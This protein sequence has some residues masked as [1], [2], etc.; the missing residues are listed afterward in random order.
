[1][2]I[3][4]SSPFH[5]GKTMATSVTVKLDPITRIEGHLSVE[6]VVDDGV[7]K[8]ANVSGTLFCGFETIMQGHS[9]LDAI[10]FAQRF[11]RVGPT[12]HA[13]ASAQALDQAFGIIPTETGRVI[14]NLVGGAKWIQSHLLHFC[15]LSA[16]DYFPD[17]CSPPFIPHF[18]GDYRLPR[19]LNEE[20]L[21]AY[22]LALSMRLKAHELSAVF[23]GKMPHDGASFSLGQDSCGLRRAGVARRSEASS[24]PLA[25]S[26][27]PFPPCSLGCAGGQGCN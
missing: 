10:Q 26:A 7:V 12:A 8:E 24:R 15:T 13:I 18:E 14:R 1:M 2:R 17:P 9:P 3:V 4:P 5:E 22:I 19:A 20:F 6:T 16:L 25:R 21:D 23:S 11:Y 27:R